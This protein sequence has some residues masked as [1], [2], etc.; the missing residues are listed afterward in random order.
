M[1]LIQFGCCCLII[2]S[3]LP[4]YNPGFF[5]AS[6]ESDSFK[7][8]TLI[9]PKPKY[10]ASRPFNPDGNTPLSILIRI[11]RRHL[12][13]YPQTYPVFITDLGYECP[14]FLHNKPLPVD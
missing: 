5:Y 7:A 4:F 11:L 8:Y 9:L 14:F 2:Q 10:K 1:H 3:N 13:H 6:A 12:F